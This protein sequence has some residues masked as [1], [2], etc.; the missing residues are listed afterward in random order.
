MNKGGGGLSGARGLSIGGPMYCLRM[1]KISKERGGGELGLKYMTRVV[2]SVVIARKLV[3]GYKLR[4]HSSGCW[5]L[6]T[7]TPAPGDSRGL[8]S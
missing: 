5:P 3:A 2:V 8:S 1:L 7:M 6:L 4:S